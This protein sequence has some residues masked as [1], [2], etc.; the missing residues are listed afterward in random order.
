[1][2]VKRESEQQHTYAAEQQ[3]QTVATHTH[4]FGDDAEKSTDGFGHCF[5]LNH[6]LVNRMP[7]PVQTEV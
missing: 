4:R 2:S 5:D 1:M 7:S 3:S 6:Q